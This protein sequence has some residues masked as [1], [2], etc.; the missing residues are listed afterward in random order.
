MCHGYLNLHLLVHR[1]ETTAVLP[2]QGRCNASAGVLSWKHWGLDERSPKRS[3]ASCRGSLPLVG[4]FCGLGGG[5]RWLLSL[6]RIDEDCRGRLKCYTGHCPQK[7]DGGSVGKAERSPR[8]WPSLN[9]PCKH[10]QAALSHLHIRRKYGTESH[11]RTF[12]STCTRNCIPLTKVAA[13]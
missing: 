12:D 5:S 9:L 8:L 11:Q 10:W 1:V 3:V 6:W 13:I 4:G 7:W 2:P